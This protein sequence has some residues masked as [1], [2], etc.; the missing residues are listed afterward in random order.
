MYL[1]RT[2]NLCRHS[3]PFQRTPSPRLLLLGLLLPVCVY[4]HPELYLVPIIEPRAYVLTPVLGPKRGLN[5]TGEV[6]FSPAQCN[7]ILATR[8]EL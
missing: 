1:G 8:A 3:R 6:R 4:V 2:A 7:I 5:Q